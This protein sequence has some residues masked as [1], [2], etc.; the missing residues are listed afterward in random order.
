VA[1]VGQRD[2]SAG[3]R[4]FIAVYN[5]QRFWT[6]VN[7]WLKR[8]YVATPKPLRWLLAGPRIALHAARGLVKDLALLRDPTARY[9][10]Y[11]RSR[12]MSWWH[13]CLDWIGGYPF[14]TAT[15]E[16]IFDFFRDRGF[17][18]ERLTTCGGGSGCNQ[19][20]FR[21]A[22]DGWSWSSHPYL[23]SVTPVPDPREGG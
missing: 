23:L 9:R 16:S 21:K 19:Y 12:G 22:L 13:D 15:S 20:V 6:P 7:T 3:A 4:L 18:L 8:A 5:H 17:V 11:N 2:D 10:H 1:G 14:E